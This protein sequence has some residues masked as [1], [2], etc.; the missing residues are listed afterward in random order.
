[1]AIPQNVDVNKG[2]VQNVTTVLFVCEN[3]D[4]FG[5]PFNS[6]C[7]K[8]RV[9]VLVYSSIISTQHKRAV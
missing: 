1:M 5:C 2:R 7:R 4:Y 8:R 6:I 3:G 9:M